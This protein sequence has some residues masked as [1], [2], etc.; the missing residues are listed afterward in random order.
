MDWL[1]AITDTAQWQ[2]IA[3]KTLRQSQARIAIAPQEFN[4]TGAIAMVEAS[5]FAAPSTWYQAGWATALLGI[6][7]MRVQ[8]SRQILSLREANLI[9]L[10]KSE[11]I[12]T[13]QISF[14]R[15][16][17]EI[18]LIVRDFIG[19]DLRASDQLERIEQRLEGLN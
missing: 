10:P 14:P 18:R 13:L 2:V 4:L 6:D 15:W 16:I 5:Y 8:V 7:N 1:P 12:Y 17:P 19:Q 3:I 11:S 9:V